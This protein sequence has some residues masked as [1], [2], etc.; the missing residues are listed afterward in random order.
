MKIYT[1]ND[2]FKLKEEPYWDEISKYTN[3]C[4]SQTLV[5][6]LTT[7]RKGDSKNLQ[8]N[9]SREDY[10][11]IYTIDKFTEELYSE[12]MNNPT[13]EIA[14]YVTISKEIDKIE[15]PKIKTSLKF[16]QSQL[17][18]AIRMLIE[19]EIYPEEIINITSTEIGAFKTIFT[20]IYELDVWKV[21]KASVS[22]LDIKNSLDRLLKME[23][24]DAKNSP[25]ESQ[26]LQLISDDIS[27]ENRIEKIVFH[28][29]HKFTPIIMKLISDL[30]NKNIEIIFLFNY[31]E[32]FNK[33]FETWKRV[34]SWTGIMPQANVN[35]PVRKNN[36]G[37]SIG[38]MMEGYKEEIL[39]KNINYIKF[40][41]LTSFC[42]YVSN[43]Y[44]EARKLPNPNNEKSLILQKMSEQFYAVDNNKINTL[45]KQYHPEQFG[46]K[47]FLAYPI[48]QFIL[49]I[50]NMW[51]DEKQTLK[52]DGRM[53]KECLST[54]F[55]QNP[56][57][58]N[59]IEI[60]SRLESYY[61]NLKIE[62][63]YYLDNL[64]DKI[65]ALIS[66]THRINSE[67]RK[68]NKESLLRKFSLYGCTI[69]ELEYFK[70]VVIDIN[71]LSK[72]LFK[73]EEIKHDFKSHFKNLLELLEHEYIDRDY[74]SIDEREMILDIKS[75]L[76][77]IEDI[78]LEGSISDIKDSIH[79]YLNRIDKNEENNEANWIVR[80][81][82]QL[83]GGVLLSK[84]STNDRIYH[85][86]LVGDI[87]MNSDNSSLIPWPL[88]ES[89]F[90][91]NKLNK[92]SCWA[93]L[94]SYK[95][96]KNFL[97]YSLFYSTYYLDNKIILSFI[98]NY[99]KDKSR[100]YFLLDILG[101]K[102]SSY[103][104]RRYLVYEGSRI[105]NNQGV[106]SSPISIGDVS[107]DELRN[108]S[109]CKYRFVLDELID[110]TTYYNSTYLQSLYY[111]TML[112]IKGWK[113]LEGKNIELVDA[114][115]N[116]L[117]KNYG[118]FFEVWKEI[119]FIDIKNKVIKNIKMQRNNNMV[120]SIPKD[121][122]KYFSLRLK[123][124]YAQIKEERKD[125]GNLI[126]ELHQ[127]TELNS[128]VYNE[129]YDFINNSRDIIKNEA[130]EKCEFCS[131]NEICLFG[132]REVL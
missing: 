77:E 110:G 17:F 46:S 25:K 37:E 80:N 116:R 93:T 3:L 119:N 68:T 66:T 70:E 39:V 18:K 92:T 94:N 130:I 28:G 74:I 44:D 58:P 24:E 99:H 123:F 100:P 14:Q 34:Y 42:D 55:F 33:V 50:Y 89:F 102:S 1:Y 21:L 121:K 101:I 118:V 23:I 27:K 32:D 2:P 10:S 97:V 71:K 60:Y 57:K 115:I 103:D 26:R 128:P 29:V 76:H 96:H 11:Y 90:E 62:D 8:K 75:R 87:D 84:S 117:N 5:Q 91:N 105:I 78:E 72:S 124:I 113:N 15:D 51:D 6:G 86:A 36:L 67:E 19:L 38:L 56:N 98:E 31:I 45:L 20:N 82:E 120:K 4:V 95:E 112:F 59:P 114:E 107:I 83:D 79:F 109:F 7:N 129:V 43:V 52:I 69:D 40:D 30:Q 22:E 81:F 47:H 108:Y 53:L 132:Y 54:G 65:D 16:N 35:I 49:S 85:L 64:I 73:N 106:I 63:N 126:K 13:N 61:E 131:Q 125:D 111:E 9:Y 41:N 104:D 48:G 88:D 122:D 12:W 127:I